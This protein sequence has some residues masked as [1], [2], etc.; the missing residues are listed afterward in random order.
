M[1]ITSRVNKLREDTR[2]YNKRNSYLLKKYGITEGQYLDLL[3]KQKG[4]CA[5]CK[6]PP[7]INLCVDHNH[8]TLE[9]RGLLCS[10]CNRRVIGRHTSA[11]LFQSAADYLSQGTGWFAPKKIKKKKRKRKR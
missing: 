8:S 4:V 2:K 11:L 3:K 5:I 7:K 6:K 1:T 10:F 9:I